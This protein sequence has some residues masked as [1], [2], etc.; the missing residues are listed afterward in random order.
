MAYIL[1]T[2]GNFK[3]RVEIEEGQ[4]HYHFSFSANG[5]TPIGYSISKYIIPS[6]E[7]EEEGKSAVL[8]AKDASCAPSPSP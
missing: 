8:Q 4:K 3:W 7:T 2:S 5:E 6:I 1:T